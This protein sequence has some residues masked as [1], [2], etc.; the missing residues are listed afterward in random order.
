MTIP[1]DAPLE[2]ADYQALAEF[3]YQIRKFLRFSEE[4][5]RKSGLKPQQHQLMLALKAAS[6]GT[7][8]RIGYLAER[9]QIQHH[10]AVELV[11]RL[12]K[13]GLVL[14]SRSRAGDRREVH[15][16]LTEKGEHVLANLTLHTRAE[17]SLAVPDFV[18]TLRKLTARAAKASQA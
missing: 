11:D 2:A 14:R 8:A 5:A 9:M 17:L 10:S 6:G 1:T 7:G 3:R 13:K 16:T 12:V 18:A 15:V 4:V